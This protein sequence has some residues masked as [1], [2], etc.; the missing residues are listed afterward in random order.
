MSSGSDE[1]SKAQEAAQTYKDDGAPTVFDKI[2]SGEWSSN[3]VYEDDR[4]LA[5]RDVNPQAP[6]HCLVIPK[7]R[8][9]LTQLCKAQESQKDLLGHLLYVAAQVGSKECPNGY[10]LVINDGADGAQ[11]VYHLHIHIMGGRQMGWPPG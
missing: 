3:K 5:F 1:V 11:S 6:V 10:R 2:I 7:Q 9:G 8:Q 4:V